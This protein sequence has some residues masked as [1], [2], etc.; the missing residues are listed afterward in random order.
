VEFI[1]VILNYVKLDF[2]AFMSL[3]NDYVAK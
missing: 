2:Y 3:V 1:T